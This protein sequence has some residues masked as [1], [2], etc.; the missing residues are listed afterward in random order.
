MGADLGHRLAMRRNAVLG[1]ECAEA[2]QEL[3]R[4]GQRRF[5][6][7]IEQ[8]QLLGIGRAPGPELEREGCQI[9]REDLGGS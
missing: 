1:V 5:G 3:A 7:L 4:L 9:G 2:A 8:R 6:R